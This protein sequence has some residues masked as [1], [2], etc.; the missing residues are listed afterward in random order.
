M[1]FL[2]RRF[3]F[4]LLHLMAAV[5]ICALPMA[6][7]AVVRHRVIEEKRA[8]ARAQL[9]GAAVSH[10]P[11]DESTWTAIQSWLADGPM[12][13]RVTLKFDRLGKYESWGPYGPNG[14]SVKLLD[15]NEANIETLG[16]VLEK[17]PGLKT[18]SFRDSPLPT[19][20]LA[21]I[22]PRC[23]HLR[24]VYLDGAEGLGREDI[25]ALTRATGLRRLN[26]R[27]TDIVDADLDVIA[28]LDGLNV[29]S[30]ENTRIT[31][32][33]IRK[34]AHLKQ[35]K[36]LRCDLTRISPEVIPIFVRWQIKELL[37]VPGEWPNED[38]KRL[39]T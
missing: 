4:R 7:I 3:R 31:D 2:K 30:F 8:I 21:K 13:S 38:V 23:D 16:P 10:A 35:L 12:P 37:V 18:L 25:A 1:M 22:L 14:T 24:N 20:M 19:G 34:I 32:I 27:C 39:K 36:S 26:L 33:G 11:R 17:L 15:W 29:L 9:L 5:T 6:W 28:K